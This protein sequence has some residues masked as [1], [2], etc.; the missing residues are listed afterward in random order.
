MSWRVFYHTDPATCLRV[1]TR[2]WVTT[3]KA[4]APVAAPLTCAKL[5]ILALPLLVAPAPAVVPPGGGGF[6]GTRGA[7]YVPATGLAGRSGGA[8]GLGAAG[9]GGAGLGGAGLGGPGPPAGSSGSAS[10]SGAA[11]RPPSAAAASAPFAAMP[12]VPAAP[13]FPEMGWGPALPLPGPIPDV[14]IGPPLEVPGESA[15]PPASVPE[16]SSFA[17]LAIGV[18][19]AA[20]WRSGVAKA[21]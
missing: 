16:P 2:I 11:D 5:G 9:L 7:S 4:V 20:L 15:G 19:A 6:G 10:V 13:Y 17:V 3:W 12:A 1:F 21:G 14:T 8:A 18:A